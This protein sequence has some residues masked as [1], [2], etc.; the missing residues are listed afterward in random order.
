MY[1]AESFGKVRQ[2]VIGHEDYLMWCQLLSIEKY[3]HS[4]GRDS[5]AVYRV[6]PNSLSGNKFKALVWHWIVLRRGLGISLLSSI[7][8]QFFYMCSSLFERIFHISN[9]KR[10]ALHS[11][12]PLLVFKK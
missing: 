12:V 7:Y 11:K 1:D 10:V 8:F 3:A 5:I 4:T 2:Q 9:T 6:S